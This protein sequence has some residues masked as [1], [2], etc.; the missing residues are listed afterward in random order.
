M[1]VGQAV[2]ALDFVDSELDLTEGLLL[3]LVEISKGNFDDTALERV[4]RV[5][6]E[7]MSKPCKPSYADSTY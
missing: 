5:F 6:Y 7:S 1:E 3:I 4:I 2:L